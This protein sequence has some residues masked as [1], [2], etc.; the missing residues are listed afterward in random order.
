M[1]LLIL[2]GKGEG[3][4]LKR[5]NLRGN[6]S[7]ILCITEAHSFCDSIEEKGNFWAESSDDSLISCTLMAYHCCQPSNGKVRLTWGFFFSSE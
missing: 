4:D 5:D 1:C 3:W 2:P 6:H 7:N